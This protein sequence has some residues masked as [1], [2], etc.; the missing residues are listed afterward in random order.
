M[1]TLTLLLAS[2]TSAGSAPPSA[3]APVRSIRLMP[4]APP[5]TPATELRSARAEYSMLSKHVRSHASSV[6]FLSLGG[7]AMAVG[8]G[9]L[10]A[11][12]LVAGAPAPGAAY[13][14][15]RDRD[16]AAYF[17]VGGTAAVSGVVML[18]L[19]LVFQS[20]VESW[21]APLEARMGFLQQRIAMLEQQ[22]QPG[23]DGGPPRLR[24]RDAVQFPGDAPTLASA[25]H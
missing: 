22:Q 8:A 2:L 4:E 1:L 24:D 11:G 10:G 14:W 5:P 7:V 25:G 3:A 23:D 6:A 17:S 18:V 20:R 12:G 16:L 15:I 21:N 9:F 19:G 13:Q